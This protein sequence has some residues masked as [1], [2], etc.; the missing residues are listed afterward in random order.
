MR[1]HKNIQ[2][3]PLCEPKLHLQKAIEYCKAFET[4]KTQAQAMQT[5]AQNVSSLRMGQKKDQS[6]KDSGNKHCQKCGYSNAWN[7]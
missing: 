5:M 6:K 3:R 4:S 2:E 1:V 7:K